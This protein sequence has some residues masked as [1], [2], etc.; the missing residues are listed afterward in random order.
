MKRS[1]QEYDWMEGAKYKDKRPGQELKA[2]F[3]R[4]PY[5]GTK[6]ET[7]DRSQEKRHEKDYLL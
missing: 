4:R 7:K 6:A 5:S 2:D 1:E 3:L